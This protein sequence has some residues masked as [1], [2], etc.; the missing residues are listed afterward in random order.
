MKKLSFI[1]IVCLCA[2]TQTNAQMRDTTLNI[3]TH[4]VD[5]NS[6]LQKSKK[7]KS[8]AWIL[9]GGGAG[10]TAVGFII[11]VTEAAKDLSNIFTPNY[12]ASNSTGGEIMVYAGIGV[13]L[14]S[15]PLFIASGKNKRK[16]NLM[17]KDENVF[18]NPKLNMKEHLVSLGIKINL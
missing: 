6:L 15:I 1:C 2:T 18:F 12:S 16:A 3:N 9:L 8:A 10:L 14:G 4:K 11:G 13:M 7:Q 5:A 17:I